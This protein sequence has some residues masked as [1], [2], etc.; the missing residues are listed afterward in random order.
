MSPHIL[1]RRISNL[2][3]F[4]TRFMRQLRGK[5]LFLQL[6]FGIVSRTKGVLA[7]PDGMAKSQ[8]R[9]AFLLGVRRQSAPAAGLWTSALVRHR[10]VLRPDSSGS[11][12][13]AGDSADPV[14]VDDLSRE[15][16]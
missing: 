9:T 6:L 2:S 8:R 12:F 15:W 1:A 14:D 7:P 4:P 3:S 11:A 5:T 10:W 13:R 16:G